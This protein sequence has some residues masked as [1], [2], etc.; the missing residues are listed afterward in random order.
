MLKLEDIKNIEQIKVNSKFRHENPRTK[1]IETGLFVGKTKDY[2]GN[3]VFMTIEKS[4]S[5]SLLYLMKYTII[6]GTPKHVDILKNIGEEE[7]EDE[8]KEYMSQLNPFYKFKTKN[9]N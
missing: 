2:N 6:N 7:D 9:L 1:K 5:K 4:R 3:P 8:F